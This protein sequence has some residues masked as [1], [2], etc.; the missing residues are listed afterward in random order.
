VR[1]EA[2]ILLSELL[3]RFHTIELAAEP[4]PVVHLIRNSWSDMNVVFGR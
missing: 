3:D 2:S 4:T 1:F